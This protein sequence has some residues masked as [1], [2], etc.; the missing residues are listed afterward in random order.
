[1]RVF[2]PTCESAVCSIPEWHRAGL[3]ESEE[4]ITSSKGWSPGAL[5]LAQGLASRLQSPLLHGEMSRLIIDLSKHPEDKDRWSSLSM[6]FTPDQRQR[7]DDRQKKQYLDTLVQRAEDALRRKDEVIHLSVDTRPD[8]E[9]TWITFSYDTRRSSEAD[10]ARQWSAAI[11]DSLPEAVIREEG[12][13]TRSLAGY[14]RT[15]FPTR[16]SS[17]RITANQSAFLDGNPIKWLELKKA[18]I[19]TVPR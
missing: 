17:V 15:R 9:D 1:M 4:V 2:I 6:G 12:T 3:K 16:F 8:M 5:N 14:L 18:L 10:W 11:R 7:L 13:P 19:E